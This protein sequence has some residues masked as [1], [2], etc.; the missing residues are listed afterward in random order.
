M[1]KDLRWLLQDESVEYKEI[2]EFLA[3]TK[4]M[5]NKRLYNMFLI[6]VNVAYNNGYRDALKFAIETE[7]KIVKK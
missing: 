3:E 5:N 6:M 4:I 1:E 2:V 7:K